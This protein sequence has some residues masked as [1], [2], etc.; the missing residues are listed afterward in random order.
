MNVNRLF[1]NK[2]K[3]QS[4]VETALVAPI[5][6]LMFLGVIEV[7]WALRNFVAVQNANREAARFAARGRYLDFSQISADDIGYAYVV[8]HEL[9]SLSGQVPLDVSGGTPNGTIIVSHVLVDTGACGSGTEDD[10]ILTP[11]TSGYGFFQAVYGLPQ[12][13]Q[14]DF[15]A[16]GQEMAAE[17]ETFNCDLAERNPGAIPSVNSAIVVETYYAHPLLVGTPILTTFLPNSDGDLWLYTKTVMR[18]TPDSRGQSATAGQGCE[19][20]PIAVHVNTLNGLQPGDSTGDIFNGA[21]PG[22]FGWLAWNDDPG[23]ISQ[24]YLEE[25]FQNPRLSH[26]TY[27][28]ASEP[29]DTYLNAG[30]WIWGLTGTVNSSGVRDELQKLVDNGTTIRIPVWDDSN[31][32]GGNLSYQ[33]QRFALVRL[34]GFDLPAKKI[35]AIFIGEDPNACPAGPVTIAEDDFESTGWNGG[36]GWTGGWGHAG[37]A[38]ITTDGGAYAGSYHLRLRNDDALVTRSVNMSGVTNAYLQFWWKANSFEGGEYA[39]VG[40]YDGS[41]HTVFTASNGD[42]DNT[43]RYADIDLSGYNMTSDFQVGIE[44][45]MSGNGDYFY[46]DDVVIEGNR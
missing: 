25:E 7:G 33:V 35:S 15:A 26:N 42:D 41:W 46:I 2:Q 21:G 27:R 5:L 37:T 40:V 29:S 14:V 22:N 44:S 16:L 18:I 9:D 11:A 32:G 34:T 10:L 28:D 20:Y 45:D 13:S 12:A 3:G 36:S 4:L 17:N 1:K 39:Y 43:Y 6:L 31:S 30:D 38:D 23:H 19:V 24:S 8:Q